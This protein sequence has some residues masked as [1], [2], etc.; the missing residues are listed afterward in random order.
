MALIYNSRDNLTRSCMLTLFFSFPYSHLNYCISTRYTTNFCLLDSS[1]R[2]C[3]K[4][5][6]IIFFRDSCSNCDDIYKKFENLKIMN[7]HKLEV[8]CFVYKFFH[9]KLPQC[10]ADSFKLNSAVHQRQTRKCNDIHVPLMKKVICGQSILHNGPKI[11]NDIPVEIRSSHNLTNF[12]SKL[13]KYLI[14]KY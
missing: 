7:I 2:C 13:K 1:Q 11:W 14:S 9:N 6:R 5:L 10:F 3:K 4:I 12:R 8:D